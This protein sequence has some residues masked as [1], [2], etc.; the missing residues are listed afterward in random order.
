MEGCAA[1][2]YEYRVSALEGALQSDYTGIATVTVSDP[3]FASEVPIA[4]FQLAGGSPTMSF[5]GSNAVVY[6]LQYNTNLM[7]PAGWYYVMSNGLPVL[8]IG[9]GVNTNSLSDTN[10]VERTRVYRLMGAP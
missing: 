4:A 10:L 3:P 2:T 5:I 9:N 6:A 1:G 7:N 8:A